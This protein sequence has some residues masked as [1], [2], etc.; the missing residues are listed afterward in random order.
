[1]RLAFLS[2]GTWM[3][4]SNL[5]DLAV[6]GPCALAIALVL[7]SQGRRREAAAWGAGF[8]A[9]FI[10]TLVL[11]ASFG[12]FRVTMLGHTFR[13]A[14]FPSGHASLSAAFYG[15]IAVLVWSATRAWAR[16][17]SA[18]L[19]AALIGL[20]GASVLALHWHHMLDIVAGFAIGAASVGLMAGLGLGRPRRI[21]EL[22]SVLGV[23]ALLFVM[24]YGARFDDYVVPFKIA[25]ATFPR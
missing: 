25:A 14:G 22:A 17:L 4:L 23:A 18:L 19:L 20:I 3:F 6:L 2:P 10:A 12:S 5:G 9:C 21:A 7:V 15:G 1:M 16:A 11:K 13:A 8:A 24:L